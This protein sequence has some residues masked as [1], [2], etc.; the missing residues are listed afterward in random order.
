MEIA[1]FE[2]QATHV[3]E[4]LEPLGGGECDAVVVQPL[5]SMTPSATQLPPSPM[6]AL[7]PMLPKA[8]TLTVTTAAPTPSRLP[9]SIQQGATQAP[10]RSEGMRMPY[11][12]RPQTARAQFRRPRLRVPRSSPSPCSNLSSMPGKGLL[13]CALQEYAR[14]ARIPEGITPSFYAQHRPS[15]GFMGSGNRQRQSSWCVCTVQPPPSIVNG[16]KDEENHGGL[17]I[18]A[19]RQDGKPCNSLNIRISP[20]C[21]APTHPEADA[22]R[23]HTAR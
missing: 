20:S 14:G 4:V 19:C 13:G 5:S 9:V 10:T 23:P 15:G 12:E 17:A 3:D 7:V 2:Q 16:I 8:Q 6:Q 18:S 1:V 22:T 11:Q 21:A